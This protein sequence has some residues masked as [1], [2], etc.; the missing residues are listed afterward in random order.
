[1]RKDTN[2]ITKAPFKARQL[3][4]LS[5]LMSVFGKPTTTG[6]QL[7][8]PNSNDLK[9]PDDYRLSGHICPD[10]K[11]YIWLDAGSVF[12]QITGLVSTSME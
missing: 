11:R 3:R 6:T 7:Q 8:L 5:V 9:T 10:L 12:K 4:S 2:T 1:M